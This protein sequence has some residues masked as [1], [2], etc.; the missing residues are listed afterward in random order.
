LR[1]KKLKTPF[2]RTLRIA[3]SNPVV[4][5]GN[6][7]IAGKDSVALVLETVLATVKERSKD[8]LAQPTFQ[9]AK[10]LKTG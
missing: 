3:K 2:R 10:D 1:A 8:L 6:K 9:K 5:R 4:T 7:R